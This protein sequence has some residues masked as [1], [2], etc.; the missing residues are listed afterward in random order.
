MKNLDDIR[1]Q[2]NSIDKEIV[3]LFEKRLN[4]VIDVANVK[5]ELGIPI[6]HL[7]REQEVLNKVADEVNNKEFIDP[8]QKLFV[9]IMRIS[10]GVQTKLLFPNNIVLVG[11][12]G[13]GKTSVGKQLASMLAMEYIDIDETIEK[14]Q[15][16]SIGSIFESKGEQ[17]FRELESKCVIELE[18]K[19]SSV[20]SCGGGIVLNNNNILS[21]KK[22]GKVFLLT[23]KPETIYTRLKQDSSRPLLKSKSEDEIKELLEKRRKL[24]MDCADIIVNTDNKSIEDICM[25]IVSQR[26]GSF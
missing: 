6:L 4:L 17:Y 19:S 21:L 18:A 1:D 25:E 12:M 8:V 2:I 11:F 13:T 14:S 24:Y 5:K 15:G 7:N 10:K 23:A 22:N 20:I 16:M 26:D 3:T 9:E